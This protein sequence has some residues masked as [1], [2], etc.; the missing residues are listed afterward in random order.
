[1]KLLVSALFP[2]ARPLVRRLA[3]KKRAL[4]RG[5]ELHMGGETALLVTGVGKVPAAVRVARALQLPELE[6]VDRVVNVGICGCSDTSVALGTVFLANKIEEAATGRSFFPDML[7]RHSFT[8]AALVTVE[9]PKTDGA[10]EPEEPMLYDMEAAGIFQ[11]AAEFVTAD[12]LHFIKIIS[13]HLEGGQFSKEWIEALVEEAADSVQGFVGGLPA[14]EPELGLGSEEQNALE[15]LRE[16]LRLTR[17][18][19]TQ[20]QDWAMAY[21]L[22][23]GEDLAAKL[24]GAARIQPAEQTTATRATALQ[25]LR[26]ELGA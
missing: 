3:L 8:E 18:Q 9:R 10:G 23:G 24:E 11:A 15:R 20:A 19:A 13:D 7:V 6:G 17:T 14:P 12:R 22:G 26:H 4:G 5:L 16:S 21:L 2:E 1:M 25:S